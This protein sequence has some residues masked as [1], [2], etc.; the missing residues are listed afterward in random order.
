MNVRLVP[1][2]QTH[3][4]RLLDGQ[5]PEPEVALPDTP[6]AE[7]EVL[8]MLAGL[9][10]AVSAL[11]TPSAWLIVAGDEL[12][13]LMSVTSVLE[14]GRL[15]IGYGVAPGSQGR[16][17]ASAAVAALVDWAQS[18]DRVKALYAETRTDN[19]ASQRVLERGGFARTGERLDEEDGALFCWQVDC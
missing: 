7:P 5:P 1:A 11:F 8:P 9:A 12:V 18:D 14:E 4:A 10:E 3:F 16:G 2:T 17:H 13:G 15:Q 19:I 6:V